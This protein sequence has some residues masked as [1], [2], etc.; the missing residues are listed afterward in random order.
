MSR[1]DSDSYLRAPRGTASGLSR[2]DPTIAYLLLALVGYLED[3]YAVRSTSGRPLPVPGKLRLQG[4]VQSVCLGTARSGL[5]VV[6]VV[7]GSPAQPEPGA[8]NR[9][10]RPEGRIRFVRPPILKTRKGRVP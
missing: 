10:P 1:Q 4:S 2:W 8:A 3:P 6:A 5:R 9:M 7:R